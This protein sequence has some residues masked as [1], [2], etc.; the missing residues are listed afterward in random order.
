YS[1][2]SALH[3]FVINLGVRRYIIRILAVDA[4]ESNFEGA[5]LQNTDLSD[6]DLRDAVF[7]N[8]DMIGAKLKGA[9]LY[10]SRIFE[11][12]LRKESFCNFDP[13]NPKK[14]KVGDEIYKHTPPAPLGPC[15]DE[16]PKDVEGPKPLLARFVYNMLMNNFRSIGNYSDE[17]WARFKE[18][19]M[20]KKRLFRLSF[21][22]DRFSDSIA[23]ERWEKQDEDK[24]FESR[25]KAFK[26]WCYRLFLSFLGYG[27]TPSKFLYLSAITIIVFTFLFLFFGFEY[28]VGPKPVEIKSSFALLLKEPAMALQDLETAFYMSVVTF[29]TLGYGDTHPIG[30]TRIIAA[31][32]A[33]IG[34]FVYSSFVATFLKRLSED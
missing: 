3:Y 15:G 1:K 31:F 19:E 13:T 4:R 21:L 2:T 23:L 6:S 17:R 18:R 16:G 12:R 8:T 26:S 24:L 7:I 5:L 25:A 10:A 30:T 27:E 20:E 29:T 22:G 32:E 34:F 9:K 11:T 14:I 28:S 33:L